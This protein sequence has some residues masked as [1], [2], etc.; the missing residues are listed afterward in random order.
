VPVIARAAGAVGEVVGDAAVVL[1]GDD[2]PATVAELL[3]IVC[4][5]GE[6]RDELA[7]RGAHR[8][9]QYDYDRTATT[10]RETLTRLAAR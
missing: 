9:T 5:D 2:G 8:L 4:G 3:R 7:A 6:L 10:V 1:N